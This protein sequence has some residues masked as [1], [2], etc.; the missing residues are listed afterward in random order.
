[1]IV[2]VIIVSTRVNPARF[3]GCL[4]FIFLEFE[5]AILN[6]LLIGVTLDGLILAPK[7][8]SGGALYFTEILRINQSV[9]P[10]T[11]CSPQACKACKLRLSESTISMMAF[12]SH[13]GCDLR[14]TFNRLKWDRQKWLLTSS[15]RIPDP[16][17]IQ[18]Q[19]VHLKFLAE[20]FG[21]D[22]IK[23]RGKGFRFNLR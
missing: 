19:T 12:M 10:D 11:R 5:I 17:H 8:F 9:S 21:K 20:R 15:K 2:T 14:Q 16:R 6:S 22:P 4:S 3:F 7:G 1:M 18:V 13:S 23:A